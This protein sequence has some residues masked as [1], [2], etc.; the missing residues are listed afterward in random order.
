MRKTSLSFLLFGLPA[1]FLVQGALLLHDNPAAA[2]RRPT[3]VQVQGLDNI[4]LGAWNGFSDLTGE[5][6][7]CVGSHPRVVAFS[8]RADGSGPGGALAI[9]NGISSLV[10]DVSYNDGRGSGWQA[11]NAGQAARGFQTRPLNWCR[12]RSSSILRLFIPRNRL[13]AATP[14]TY[15]GTLSL[16]IVPE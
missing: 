2:Q 13:A 10:L 12:G 7:H 1:G 9:T 6:P 11:L 4:N 14:G 3:E 5:D 15:R 16:T 8:L